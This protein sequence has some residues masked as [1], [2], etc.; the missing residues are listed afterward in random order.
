M[1][2]NQED[3]NVKNRE[4]VKADIKKASSD[5]LASIKGDFDKV[6]DEFKAVRQEMAEMPPWAKQFMDA[7]KA[8][9]SQGDDKATASK[10]DRDKSPRRKAGREAGAKAV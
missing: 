1:K 9:S 8:S 3:E 10:N 7:V 5:L 6:T 2:K 4:E